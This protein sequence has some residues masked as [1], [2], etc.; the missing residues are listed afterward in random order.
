M[1]S[2]REQLLEAALVHLLKHGLVNL[3]LRTLAKHIG[4]SARML[5]FH[6]NS[7]EGL[8]VAALGEL[9]ER[10]QS[11]FEEVSARA[12]RRSTQPPLRMFWDWASS[13]EN[14]PSLRLLYELQIAAVQNPKPYARYLKKISA[15]W[16]AAASKALSDTMR[17]EPMATLCIAVFDGLFLE[18][19]TTGDRARLSRALN[20]FIEIARRGARN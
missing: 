7:K 5:V 3:S 12:D 13:K 14:L 15:D 1:Q 16:Q 2:R 6:F 19:I 20:H 17:Q 11:S 18:L 4:T 8:I 9:N 10:L